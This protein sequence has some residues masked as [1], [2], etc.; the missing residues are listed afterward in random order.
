MKIDKPT[1]ITSGNVEGSLSATTFVKIGGTSAQFLKADGSVSTATSGTITVK[2][3][4]GSPN[5]GTVSTIVVSNG[6]LTDDGG[7]QVTITTGGGGGSGTVTSVIAGSGMTQTG[8]STINPTLNVIGGTGIIANDDDIAL[9]FSSLTDMT[10]SISGTTEFILQNGIIESR[11]AASEISLGI[12]NNDQGWTSNTGDITN[13]GVTAPITGGGAS[14]DVTIGI[15]Q[16]TTSTN[17]YLSSTDW[18]TFNGKTSNTGDITR[19]NITAGSGLVG[20]VDTTSGDHTQTLDLEFT[21]IGT[22]GTLIGTDYLMAD[23]G[24]ANTR[25]LISSIPL[26]IFNNNLSWTS[27]VGTVT[28]VSG[29]TALTSTG[30]ATPSLSLDNT[31]VTA[32]SYT[33]ADITVDAQGRITAASNGSGGGGMTSFNIQANGG[34]QIAITDSEEINFINGNVTTAVVVNQANPTVTFNLNNTAVTPGSY[35]SSDITIDAQGRITAASSGAGGSGDIT[36]VNI[37]AG[38][39]LLGTVDTTSGDHTQ[40]INLDINSLS[41]SGTLIGT[42][43]IAV[44]DGTLTRKTQIST[45]PLSIFNN[46]QGWTSNIDGVTSIST[47]APITGGPITSTGTI[48]ITQATTST[49]G[50]LSSTDWNTFNGKTSNTG[51]ITRVNITAGTGLSGSVNTASGDHTQTIN[52]DNTTVTAGSYTLTDI[53]VD[54]QGRITAASSGTGGGG[55]SVTSVELAE[56]ALIDLSG[57]NPITTSGTITVAVDLSELTDMGITNLVG[58]DELVVLDASAQKRKIINDIQLGLFDNDQGWTSSVDGV[59]SVS[60]G[61]G[62]NFTTITGTG[63]VTMGLPSTITDSSTNSVAPGTHSHSIDHASTTIRGI[64]QL[65]NTLTSTSTTIALTAAQG[66]VLQDAKAPLASPIFTGIVT[67]PNLT[68]SSLSAQAAEA[69]A[70]MINGSNVV[71]TRELGSNAFNSTTIPT[72]T[73]AALTKTNDTNVTLTLGGSPE[74]ALLQGASITVGWTGTLADGRI[75]SAG[76]WNGKQDA[77]TFGIANTNSVV[78]NSTTVATGEYAKF[79]A[80]GLESRTGAEVRSDIGAGTGDGDI[81]NVGVTAPITGGGASGSV[82]IGITQATTSTNGYLSSTDWNTFNGKTSNTGDITRVNIT[83]GDGLTGTVDTTSGDHTQT[84]NVVG[85]GGITANV[86]NITIGGNLGAD[87]AG[88]STYTITANDFILGSDIRLKENIK[89]LDTVGLDIDYVEFNYKTNKDR[90]RAG[91][92]ANDIEEKYP[93]LVLENEEGI[94]QVS[95]IDMLIREVVALKEEVRKLKNK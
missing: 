72:V 66:K 83:A 45:I 51:D 42:D 57:T 32:G 20:T 64:V 87:W 55:G 10:A 70:L 65:N 5:V 58:T 25:Q 34:T 39:G 36:R 8:T 94:K 85:T 63:T 9:D 48:G 84:I 61:N 52:L 67:T 73:P 43:D 77:L 17:G 35:T 60:A 29:G 47:T 54:A 88:G 14:G 16:A 24:N 68:L 33:L 50:Y 19:V 76:T 6:T 78:I 23:N 44:A 31:A 22:G 11:K 40:T 41:A 46:D 53:T 3:V 81:T 95:Y 13:V 27:N 80:S 74:T 2:E 91:V 56:G 79:T 89:P 82:T 15:T 71:G 1:I 26:S 69:T 7:G 92:I 38:T 12:F 4:D 30:G 28:S 62:M 75:A 21:E 59:T 86:D 49:N 90:K 37:T 18:N 93:E